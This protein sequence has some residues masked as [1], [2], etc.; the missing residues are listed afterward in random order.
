MSKALTPNLSTRSSH[1]ARAARISTVEIAHRQLEAARAEAR[2]WQR[3]LDH[4]LWEAQRQ[5]VEVRLLAALT[6]YSVQA[7][8]Q[9]IDRAKRREEHA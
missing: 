2:E 5:G 1:G 6:G 7:I 4:A 3:A 9:A 8:Y